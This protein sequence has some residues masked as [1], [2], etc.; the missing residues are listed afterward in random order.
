[1]SS[2]ADCI[3]EYQNTFEEDW[4]C[5]ISWSENPDS[6]LPI[7]IAKIM[8]YSA[9]CFRKL[10]ISMLSGEYV[11]DKQSIRRELN[12]FIRFINDH[13]YISE[14]TNYEKL[15]SENF[16]SLDRSII[17]CLELYSYLICVYE[18][19]YEGE[20]ISSFFISHEDI[21]TSSM[22][23]QLR[24]FAEFVQ[25]ICKIEYNLSYQDSLISDLFY[26]S[27]SLSGAND[28]P[29][30]I[31]T[32][33]IDK[34]SFLL[35]KLQHVKDNRTIVYYDS[36]RIEI[37]NEDFNSEKLEELKNKFNHLFNED[38]LNNFISSNFSSLEYRLNNDSGNISVSDMIT[39]T[40]CYQ[41]LS[42]RK[43]KIQKVIDLFQTTPVG[44]SRY[45][46]YSY[47]VL[48]NYFY[49]S[50]FSEELKGDSIELEDFYNAYHY[51]LSIQR[52]T[53][54]KNFHPHLKALEYIKQRITEV[55]DSEDFS[56][57]DDLFDQF[58]NILKIFKNSIDWCSRRAFYAFQLSY[59]DSLITYDS[60]ISVFY[61]SSFSRPLRY[62]KLRERLSEFERDYDIFFAQKAL[63]TERRNIS[64]IKSEVDNAKKMIA[65]A[66]NDSVK[67][68]GVFTTI[69]TFLFGSIDVFAKTKDFKETLLASLGL[70]MV[71]YLFTTIIYYFVASEEDYKNKPIRFHLVFWVMV[72][73]MLVIVIF[74][75]NLK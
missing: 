16:N 41:K 63:I 44:T 20:S 70:G 55:I 15:L 33:L 43:D 56:S 30:D 29:D 49:N 57:Y 26:M 4:I 3:N 75:V 64:Q 58:A 11:N 73:A 23:G 74:Y 39:L 52:E 27:K 13:E 68:L 45:D 36:I 7:Y 12:E 17:K 1:M 48:K 69:V 31:K 71:L 18:N 50:L 46:I 65:D 10:S 37:R 28:I 53:D 38:E 19:K 9:F 51:I 60:G 42:G 21:Y 34:V 40:K 35:F 62:D 6:D 25:P 67:I 66:K 32:I 14:G 72:L 24:F 61:P 59:D 2:I 5:N 47:N 22:I 54:I 8:G